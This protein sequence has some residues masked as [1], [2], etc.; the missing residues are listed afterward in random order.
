[1][2]IATLGGGC[3]W[4][5]EGALR[6]LDGVSS[7]TSGYAGGRIERP[8]YRQ[9]CNG[10]TDHA[11]VVRVEFDP[12]VI[13][14]RTFGILLV[15]E[16]E[17]VVEMR[18]AVSYDE[19]LLEKRVMLGE[20]LVGYAALHKTPVLVPDV[21]KDPRYIKVMLSGMPFRLWNALGRVTGANVSI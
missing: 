5:I 20:G 7:V 11:E 12:A 6:L 13:D 16:D 14:Y 1:M 8:S 15:N 2:E 17:G 4:C 9:I 19:Q 21:S 18:H 10:D 3:F